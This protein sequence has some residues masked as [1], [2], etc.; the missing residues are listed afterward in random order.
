MNILLIAA[1][2]PVIAL[3]YY[4]Y[5]KDTH[6]EPTDLLLKIFGMGCLIVIPVLIIEIILGHFFPSEGI[7]NFMKVFINTFISVAIV[8]EA[9]KWIVTKKYG[10]NSDA[11]DEIYDII[12]Y[13]VFASLGFAA[14]ENVLYVFGGGLATAFVRALL[15]IPGHTCFGVLMGYYLAKAKINSNSGNYFLCNKNMILSLLLPTIGHTIYDAILLF[16]NNI[17]SNDY[18]IYFYLFFIILVVVCFI[19][20]TK[21]SK[22]QQNLSINVKEGNIVVPKNGNIEVSNN[23]IEFCPICGKNVKGLNYC[24]YCGIKL[25]K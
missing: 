9:F 24:P 19:I 17:K 14:V 5:I 15:S 2:L 16:S 4:I 7:Y 21:L 23:N 12:V 1:L 3:G 25:K 13:A 20:V 8:E 18:M 6:T 11:F 10:Y 22:M